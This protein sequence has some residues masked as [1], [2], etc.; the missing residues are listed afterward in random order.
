MLSPVGISG[1]QGFGDLGD[2]ATF[3]V[4]PLH[5]IASFLQSKQGTTMRDYKFYSRQ[6]YESLFRH[7]LARQ[8]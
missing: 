2:L 4:Q 5:D 7:S 8:K 1:C 3:G 6:L